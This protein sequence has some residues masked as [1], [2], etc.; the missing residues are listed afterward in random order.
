MEDK[1]PENYWI[2]GEITEIRLSQ[3]GHCFLRLVEKDKDKIVAQVDAVVWS[4]R[5]QELANRF[6]QYTFIPLKQ[7]LKILFYAKIKFHEVFG[8]KLDIVD[9]DPVYSLGEM[10]QMKRKIINQLESEGII[11]LNKNLVFPLVPQRIAVISSPFAAG[12]DDFSKHL[13]NNPYGYKFTIKLF[14]A[15]MQ[16]EDAEISILTQLDKIEKE[17]DNFDVVVVT[18]GGGSQIDL[19]CFDNYKIAKKIAMC[20]LPVLTGIGHEKDETI[21]DIVAHKKLKTPTAVADF[22]IHSMKSFEEKID[23]FQKNICS[24]ANKILDHEDQKL[25]LFAQLLKTSPKSK[26]ERENNRLDNIVMT[27]KMHIQHV[28]EKQLFI[29]KNISEPLKTFPYIKIQSEYSKLDKIIDSIKVSVSYSLKN[30][31]NRLDK[32]NQIMAFAD[33]VNVLK[34]GYSITYH[35]GKVIKDICGLRKYDVIYTRLYK[36]N[37]ESRIE[38][39]KGKNNE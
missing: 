17:K 18:R 28:F 19:S 33:P 6:K 11:N 14:E 37:I 1:F 24:F 12:Y 29:L 32:F 3:N 20:Q 27:I 15:V 39:I 9:I 5:Y 4:D 25:S 34:R 23:Y 10:A 30:E 26:V 35:K 21:V 16:G 38:S 22:L 7:G 13:Q 36:G 8:L 2:V 31:K